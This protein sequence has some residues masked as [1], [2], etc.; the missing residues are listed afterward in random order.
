MNDR[1]F[2]FL[3]FF[4]DETGSG[5][6]KA[7]GFSD[8]R[9][10]ALGLSSRVPPFY[11]T[12]VNPKLKRRNR[13]EEG[14]RGEE[15]ALERPLASERGVGWAANRPLS[16]SCHRRLRQIPLQTATRRRG[17]GCQ[18]ANFAAQRSGAIV[19]Q[20][21]RAKHLRGVS[22]LNVNYCTEIKALYVQVLKQMFS[23]TPTFIVLE[24]IHHPIH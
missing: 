6:D 15:R 22:K 18:M 10:S 23:S 19:L 5:S 16:P 2:L 13:V 7:Y 4:L 11:S 24:L 8:I 14:E 3:L 12:T 1:A 17:Q 21:R 20:A 9:R